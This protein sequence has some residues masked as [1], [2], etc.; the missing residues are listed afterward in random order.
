MPKVPL[1][2]DSSLTLVHGPATPPLLSSS[3]LEP[4]LI[5]GHSDRRVEER[6]LKSPF[7]KTLPK[8]CSNGGKKKKV[9]ERRLTLEYERASDWKEPRFGLD[10]G[11]GYFGMKHFI[12]DLNTRD[13]GW[14]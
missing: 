2:H 3:E 9:E 8:D 7:S 11:A 5:P 10:A 13:D 4:L 1:I 14:I 6:R 12:C